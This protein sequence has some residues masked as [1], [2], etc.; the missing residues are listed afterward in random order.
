MSKI[1]AVVLYLI[2]VINGFAVPGSKII[3]RSKSVLFVGFGF[4]ESKSNSSKSKSKKKRNRVNELIQNENKIGEPPRPEERVDKWGLPI[5]SK[6]EIL[7]EIF[8]PMSGET[9]II[10]VEP[11]KDY[12][13][14]EIQDCLINHI[15]L[16]L[17]RRFDENGVSIPPN[18]G[19]PIR[20]KLL[21][22]SPPVLEVEN[23]F[24]EEECQELKNAS[25]VGHEVSSATFSGALSTRTSTS[26]FCNYYDVPLFLAKVNQYLNI[27]LEVMEEPQIVRYQKGQEFSWHYDEVPRSA[28]DNGGQRLITILLYISD[29]SQDH[30]GGTMFRDLKY[31]SKPLVVQPKMGSA[32]L[33]FPASN[34]GPDERTLH[35][36]QVL[37]D[38]SDNE[39]VEKW[40]IQMWCHERRYQAVLPSGNSQELAVDVLR[41]TISNLG[42]A[43]NQ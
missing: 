39:E 32:L 29:V 10:P 3:F 18:G 30:G 36:S 31:D 26:W 4:G 1:V 35:Q 9:E 22:K 28:L 23:F 25:L 33:F 34:D 24:S 5:Q 38:N 43:E 6:E 14:Q 40:I 19:K 20:L 8:P 13:L 7:Q 17:G 15:D 37:L 2:V 12:T 41:K 42:L 21:H 16:K 27:P 11:G